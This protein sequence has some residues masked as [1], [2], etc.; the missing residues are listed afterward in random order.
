MLVYPLASSLFC[1][2]PLYLRDLYSA[3]GKIAFWGF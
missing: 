3:S 1:F 2:E